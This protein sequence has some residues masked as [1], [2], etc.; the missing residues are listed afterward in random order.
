MSAKVSIIN[1][2]NEL[3][4]GQ[5]VNT[6]LSWLGQELAAIGLPIDRSVTVRD[7]ANAI[8][9]ALSREWHDSDVVIMTGGLGP[10]KDDI[11]KA[12]IAGFFEKKLEFRQE[13][14]DK[15]QLVFTFRGMQT[16][17][18]NRSQAMVPAGF[19]AFINT[20]GTAPGLY[21]NDNGKLFFAL[22]GVP[23][24][25]KYLFSEY[26]RDILSKTFPGKPVILR[27][28]HTWK[29]SESAL[30]ERL[31]DI[32]IPDDINLAWLP[33]TGRVDLRIYGSD[34][35]SISQLYDIIHSRI[36]ENVWGYDNDNP[37]SVLHDLML[38]KELTLSAAESCTGGLV[39][40]LITNIPGASSYFLGSIVS[41]NNLL[42]SH[43]LDV[44]NHTL[45]GFGAVSIETA[46]EMAEG[47][48]NKTKSDIG[49]SVTGITGPE[50][51]SKEKPVGTVC[52]A[53]ASKKGTVS[54][55]LIFNGDRNTIS[56]KAAEF[57]ILLLID[58]VRREI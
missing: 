17:E 15:V 37:S 13:I 54:Q 4:L 21:Y 12:V 55:R 11:T 34:E 53:I 50:G 29:T 46:G 10:T 22:P 6:N 38:E 9:S 26:I 19:E 18:I 27:T 44:K 47:I 3:L 33:Q 14:W 20:L 43:L 40:K 25:M 41:Y 52:F 35:A 57:S 48:R 7:D 45:E 28:I 32:P 5:S 2:G 36:T 51:G 31:A 42:K 58:Y 16:P 24:E 30:A 39:G 56:F 8:N 23:V 1:I 49:I